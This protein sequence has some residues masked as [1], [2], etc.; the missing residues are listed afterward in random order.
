MQAIALGLGTSLT[1]LSTAVTIAGTLMSGIGAFQ[2]SQYQ[3]AVL[4]RQAEI[5][6]RNADMAIERGQVRAQE[7]DI[8]A[9]FA[10][11][12]EKA[13]QGASGFSTNS[14]SFVQR[15]R[16]NRATADLN[17]RRLV[18][19]SQIESMNFRDS[20]ATNRIEAQGARSAGRNALFGTAFQI[21]TDLISG[22]QLT[23][24]TKARRLNR[25]A[26]GING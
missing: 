19:D 10:M 2:S 3:A 23:R 21:G 22:A 13:R 16:R 5:D 24:E 9:M 12:A 7:A 17:R 14:P 15:R 26:L 25:Q 18:E 20:A 11:G 1:G 8:D 4:E 6:K